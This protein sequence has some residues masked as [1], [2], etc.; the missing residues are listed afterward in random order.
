MAVVLPSP[1]AASEAPCSSAQRRHWWGLGLLASAVFML[2]LLWLQA[3]DLDL[4][5]D[6]AQYWQW[7]QALDFGYYSK[8]PLV[9]WLI[10]ASTWLLGDS[11][12]AIRL[13]ALIAW[14]LSALALAAL[15]MR[16]GSPRAAWATALLFLSMPGQALGAWA[17]TPDAFLLLFWSLGLLLLHRAMAHGKA[18]DWIGL[19]LCIGVGTLAKYSML[20]FVIGMLWVLW[21]A[22]RG[23]PLRNGP[24]LAAG[25]SAA[26]LAPNLWWNLASGF[27]TVRHTAEIAGTSAAGWLHPNHL[28]EFLAAQWLIFGLLSLPWLLRGLW[29]ADSA[30][31]RWL[32]PFVLPYLLGISALALA[33]RRAAAEH[34]AGTGGDGAASAAAMERPL[35]SG[36]RPAFPRQRLARVG[37]ST[38]A[39]VRCAAGHA[40]AEQ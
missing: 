25:V 13:P 16:M 40:T 6:E 14:P 23:A 32:R 30:A 37:R 39:A 17:M 5:I 35:Q 8:P 28:G 4:F 21:F 9:A 29:K 19:G 24:W 7:A 18:I 20:V 27:E 31:L 38:A 36:T 11:E 1:A 15:A 26:L 2:R 3:Q 12:L 10:A 22:S 33:G 34:R